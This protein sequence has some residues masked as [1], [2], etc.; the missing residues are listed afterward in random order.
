MTTLADLDRFMTAYE[1]AN[2]S[3]V[4]T[5]VEPFIALD[6]V[7]WFND[8]S[9]QGRAAIRQAVEDTFARI[10]DENYHISDL[11]WIVHTDR[12]AVCL[13]RFAWQGFV[14]G[15]IASG[16]GR[17]TNVLEKRDGSWLIVHEHLSREP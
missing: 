10:K 17:G 4:W 16:Q 7:Y 11:R 3:H 2:T 12:L 14:E 5:R 9:Y 6:A 1:Q 13:Y 8:G 15:E